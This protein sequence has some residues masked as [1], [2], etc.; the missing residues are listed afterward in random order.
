MFI[1]YLG[2]V[3]NGGEQITSLIREIQ[4]HH[5][6]R[7][8]EAA[9]L[10]KWRHVHNKSSNCRVITLWL[11]LLHVLN[12]PLFIWYVYIYTFLYRCFQCIG[13][14]FRGFHVF[15]ERVWTHIELFFTGCKTKALA[16]SR[17]CREINLNEEKRQEWKDRH[18]TDLEKINTQNLPYR[19]FTAA[20]Q[21]G[22]QV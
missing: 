19:V 21:Y 15:P 1:V 13:L 6:R 10:W 9:V 22:R 11:L 4:N 7:H 14:I 16:V 8:M 20:L 18:L 12:T 3:I 17:Q 2:S 5:N